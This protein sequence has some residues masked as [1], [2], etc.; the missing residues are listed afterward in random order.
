MFSLL[1]KTLQNLVPEMSETERAALEAGDVWIEGDFFAGRPDFRQL[2]AEPW[3]R[4]TEREEAFLA[5]PV[6]EACALVDRQQTAR[7]RELAPEVW[8]H[9]KQHRFFGLALPQRYGGHGF[10]ALAMS[11]IFGKLASRSPALSTVVLIPNSVGPGELL[12]EVGTEEQ[13]R[14]YLPLLSRG[15]EIPCF[16]LTEPTAGSDAAAITSRGELFRDAAGEL[17][18]RLDWEKRY[19]TLAPI[20]TLLGLAF[21]LDDP[22]NLLGKGEDV[23]ITCALVSTALPGV[24]IGRYHDPLGVPFPNGPTRGRGVVI[25]AAEIIGGVDHAGGGWR[26]LMEALSG[27]R[28]I[29]LPAGAAAGARHVARVAGAY[30]VVRQQFGLE[31]GRFE[32]VEEPLARIAGLAYLLDAARV[33]TCGALDSGHRPAVASALLKYNSTEIARRLAI[34]GMDVLGGAAIC[35]GP[36]NLMADAY[37]AAPIGITVEGANILTRTLIVFGQGALRCHPHLHALSETIRRGDAKG[38]RRAFFGHLGHVAGSALRALVLGLTRGRLARSPVAGPTAKYYR[39][40]AWAAA[41]FAFW[42]DA[43]V[44]AFGG[45]LKLKGKLTGRFADVLSWMVLGFAALR[46]Y[47]AQGRPA[48]DLPLVR[49]SVEH[50]LERIQEGFDGIFRNFDVPLAGA[51]VRGPVRSWARL[52]PIGAPP[53]DRLGAQAA[54]ALRTPGADRDRLIGDLFRSAE[55]EDPLNRLEEAFA[56]VVESRPAVAKVRRA[57]RR[58]ELP[59]KRPEELVDEAL[60]AGV[61]SREEADL[62][63]RATAARLAAIEVDSMTLEEF[64]GRTGAIEEAPSPVSVAG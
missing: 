22:D 31:I 48:A 21:R 8:A 15:D 40:L 33:M 41:R 11:A 42:S 3:P 16:A 9:L 5:G 28:A 12:L 47:E 53:T 61:L 35:R 46:R 38:F 2:L 25:P 37:V 51:L 10:S 4:L 32:G 49:W 36:R 63:T 26:M 52:N 64:L 55:A 19:I 56:L 24:E 13:R 17:M 6:A 54:A 58:G 50:A 34:D 14:H 39:R 57:I 59:K 27:G 44:A 45:R 1:L 7:T 62:L 18:I 43:A 60:A 20:A 29:S 23:G 30:S